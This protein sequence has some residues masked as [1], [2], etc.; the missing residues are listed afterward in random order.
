MVRTLKIKSHRA[1]LK[2]KGLGSF[3]ADGSKKVKVKSNVEKYYCLV[4]NIFSAR[5]ACW[6]NRLFC[7][8]FHITGQS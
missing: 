6:A 1:V 7:D 8:S 4:A 5:F 2:P 3:R